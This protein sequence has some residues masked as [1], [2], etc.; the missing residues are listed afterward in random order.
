MI[1]IPAG[2]TLRHTSP[3][4]RPGFVS[5]TIVGKSGCGK[6]QLLASVLPGISPEIRTIIIAT[7]VRNV[8]LHLAIK[9]FFSSRGVFCGIS[10]DPE[11]MRAFVEMSERL[12]HV[13]PDKQGLIIFDDFNTGRATGPYWDF[14]IHAFT[15]L[16]NSGWNFIIL[17]QQPSF[18]P[19]IVRNCTTGRVLFDCYSKSALTTF[20]RD[21]A[22]RITDRKAYDALLSY[23]QRVPF[24]YLLVQEHPFTVSAGTLGNFRPVLTEREVIMPTMRDLMHEMNVTTPQQLRTKSSQQQKEAGNTAEELDE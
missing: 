13:T 2:H 7:A 14:T 8:P 1:P 20:T 4:F 21:V 19:T 5:M 23:I 10:H 24:T 9:K 3:F 6:T 22:D 18:I 16:R 11:E 15:K 17:S 12:R